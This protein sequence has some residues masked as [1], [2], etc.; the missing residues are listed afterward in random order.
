MPYFNIIN[1]LLIHIPKTGG[2]SIENYFYDKFNI[3]RTLNTL[4]SDLILML[5]SHSLQHSSFNELFE[6]NLSKTKSTCCINS[7]SFGCIS[8]I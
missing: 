8:F 6:A 1:I 5:N 2:T 4:Y 3:K 7:N